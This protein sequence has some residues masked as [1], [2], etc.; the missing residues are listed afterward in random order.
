MK[1]L[2]SADMEGVA[3]VVRDEQTD[4]AG[5]DYPIARRLMTLEVNAAIEGALEAG[6]QE[7]VVSDG[8]W[9]GTNLLPDDLRWVE[10]PD[11]RE[12]IRVVPGEMRTRDARVGRHVAISPGALHRF[13]RRF[14]ERLAHNEVI[15]GKSN[16]PHKFANVISLPSGRRATI[17]AG[18][19]W[20]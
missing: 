4:P 13:M 5:R 9:A 14:E 10:N 20:R 7:I 17:G 15:V 16:K 8:H 11:T 18:S 6:V 3:G 1:I 2:I 12:K 19:A